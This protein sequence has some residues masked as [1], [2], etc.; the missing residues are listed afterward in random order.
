MPRP[1]PRQIRTWRFPPSGSSVDTPRGCSATFTSS[2]DM[3]SNV[4]ALSMVPSVKLVSTRVDLA[5]SGP[6]TTP[7]P[8]VSA[9][10]QPSD[11][12]AP[13]V[14]TLVPLVSDLP[15]RWTLVLNRPCMRPRTQGAL[16][17]GHRRSVVPE[18][19]CGETR[20]SQVTGPSATHVPQ[21]I[22]PPGGT[23]PRPVREG[24]CGLQRT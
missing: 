4:N 1:G 3:H 24:P 20:V 17:R 9:T 12:L 21:S 19:L 6:A 23:S 16:E 5:R 22:T 8:D 10:T 14:A 7:F 15:Q 11:S 18:I 2:G 13:S